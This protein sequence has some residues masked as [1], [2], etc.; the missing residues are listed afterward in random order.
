VEPLHNG[1]VGLEGVSG[2]AV[3]DLGD[4]GVQGR[5]KVPVFCDEPVPDDVL[6]EVVRSETRGL[7]PHDI[8]RCEIG[9]HH[10]ESNEDI[11][12]PEDWFLD[13]HV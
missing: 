6:V 2:E 8:K 4:D 9:E 12:V 7:V 5:E 10:R 1:E 13:L 11:P 3:H